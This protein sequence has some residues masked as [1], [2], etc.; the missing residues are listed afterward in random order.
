MQTRPSTTDDGQ[1]APGL[2]FDDP[3][4]MAVLASLVG[5]CHIVAGFTNRKLVELVSLLINASY[6]NRQATYDLR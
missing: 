5:F 3:R 1:Y 2:R 4:V 6:T